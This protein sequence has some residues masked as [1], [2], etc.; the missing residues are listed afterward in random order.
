MY[1]TSFFY[2]NTYKYTCRYLYKLHKG[3]KYKNLAYHFLYMA[4]TLTSPM[5]ISTLTAKDSF[6]ISCLFHYCSH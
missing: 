5:M 2:M 4:Y 6:I 3:Q 1:V